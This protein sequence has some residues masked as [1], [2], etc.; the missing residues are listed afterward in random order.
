K[1]YRRVIHVAQLNKQLGSLL[2]IVGLIA[3]DLVKVCGF[4]F[5]CRNIRI[6][7][8]FRGLHRPGRQKIGPEVAGIHQG[9]MHVKLA[10]FYSERFGEAGNS[11]FGGTIDAEC[12]KAA[13][14][15][16]YGGNV[17]NMSGL[18]LA[19]VGGGMP[20][21]IQGAEDRKSTRLNSSHVKIS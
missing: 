6:D 3:V 4:A 17:E 12:R 21:D 9:G 8:L 18:L 15:P 10:H 19:K 2:R 1:V 14:Q 13:D 7:S 20:D 5:S 16:A 11:K